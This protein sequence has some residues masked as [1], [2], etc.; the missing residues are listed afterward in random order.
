M[1]LWSF[2]ARSRVKGSFSMRTDTR[3][4]NMTDLAND[5]TLSER[6]HAEERRSRKNI[7]VLEGWLSAGVGSVLLLIGAILRKRWGLG[8]AS[9]GGY[10]L[11][12]GL[13]RR[14]PIYRL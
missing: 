13:S 9:V 1:A 8:L 10:L 7:G 14:D 6:I 12:R 5:T 4:E 2:P 3:D 11:Y